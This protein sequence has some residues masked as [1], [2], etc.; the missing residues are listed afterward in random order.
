MDMRVIFVF[1]MMFLKGAADEIDRVIFSVTTQSKR[2]QHIEHV[3]KQ[4]LQQIQIDGVT[5]VV[6]L[7]V[8]PSVEE[9]P[10]WMMNE[11]DEFRVNRMERD[12]G[13]SSKILGTLLHERERSTLI[14]YG[15][16][17][18]VLPN[19]IVS[20][21]YEAHQLYDGTQHDVAFG[22]RKIR[23]G[24]DFG[25]HPA[26]DILEATGT[27]SIRADVLHRVPSVFN[28]IDV[29]ACRLSDDFWISYHFRLAHVELRTLPCTYDFH[30][31][32]WP[33][34]LCGT[35]FHVDRTISDIEALSSVVVDSSGNVIPGEQGDWRV[36]L[37]RYAM[38]DRM[39]MRRKVGAEEL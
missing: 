4:M 23:I 5:Y 19:Q 13:P 35:P 16:D 17:D 33:V 15:D 37:Q 38:C 3:L 2:I 9:L 11:T 20:M 24:K 27:I 10:S 22:T 28:V 8:P 6:Q 12:F 36:Q 7:N 26:M 29:D 14:V 1:V 30:R 32:R 31:N 39:M 21:H 18:I 34:V 25:V